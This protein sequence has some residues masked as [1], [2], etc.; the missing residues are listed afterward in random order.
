MWG[1]GESHNK[2]YAGDVGHSVKQ[3]ATNISSTDA[4]C[5]THSVLVEWASSGNPRYVCVDWVRKLSEE[6][7]KTTQ[8]KFS[9]DPVDTTGFG[10]RSV[11]EC[12]S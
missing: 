10:G 12:E 11:C 1:E 4:G 5:S 7:G 6:S 2:K 8:E 3:C 9:S